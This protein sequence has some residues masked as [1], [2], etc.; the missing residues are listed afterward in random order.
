M[1]VDREQFIKQQHAETDEKLRWSA[2]E[3]DAS[4]RFQKLAIDTYEFLVSAGADYMQTF[5][6]SPASAGNPLR[7]RWWGKRGGGTFTQL[8]PELIERWESWN[9]EYVRI[10]A[11]NPRLELRDVMQNISESDSASSWPVSY[12]RHIWDWIEAG[13]SAA[14]LPSMIGTA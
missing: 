11:R 14:P 13:D 5:D 2:G 10:R 6:P 7:G 4:E 8:S 3:D 9:S 12:E 1:R